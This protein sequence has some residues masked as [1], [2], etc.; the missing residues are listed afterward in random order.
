[1]GDRNR[2]ALVLIL[3][4]G[5]ALRLFHLDAPFL[6]SHAWRQLDTAAMAR[7]F[8]EG[9]FFPFD[10]QVDWGGKD[11]Y[12][13]AEFPLVPAAIAVV[14]RVAGLHET[15]ARLVIILTSL[16]LIWAVYRL[17]L[18]LD[19]RCP[20]RAPRLPDGRLADGGVLRAHRDSRHADGVLPGRGAHRVRGVRASGSRPLAD[21]R[22]CRPDDCV[23][24]EAA[25]RVRRPGDRDGAR[26]G[27]RLARVSRSA[28]LGVRCRASGADRRLVP[29]TR[30]RSSC[31]LV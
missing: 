27:A 26:A 14:Y 22:R 23:P 5:A 13:E 19:G 24:A 25:R 29:G 18:A 28:R 7:N 31:A 2:L 20:R 12:L 8:Y 15:L 9:S 21:G 3:A 1:M 4:L 16:G 11:G 30:T 10:P 6:D 17:S